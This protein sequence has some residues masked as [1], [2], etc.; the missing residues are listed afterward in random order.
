MK[1]RFDEDAKKFILIMFAIATAMFLYF[2]VW[3]ETGGDEWSTFDIIIRA[4][5][6]FTTAVPPV[7]PLCMTIGIEFSTGRLRNKK[8]FC[9]NPTILSK[10]PQFILLFNFLPRVSH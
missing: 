7:L 10:S 8:I 4:L 3:L 6:I 9:I 2:F 5:E 1:F